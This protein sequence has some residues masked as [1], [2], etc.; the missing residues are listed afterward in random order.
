MNIYKKIISGKLYFVIGK[1]LFLGVGIIM[2]Q[3]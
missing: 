2:G 3:P 1:I